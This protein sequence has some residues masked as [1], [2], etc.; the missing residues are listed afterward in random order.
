[1]WAYVSGI[2]RVPC[3]VAGGAPTYHGPMALRTDG[4]LRSR[5]LEVLEKI[6]SWRGDGKAVKAHVESL[7]QRG[8]IDEMGYKMALDR[9][10]WSS[11]VAVMGSKAQTFVGRLSMSE[12]V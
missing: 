3:C 7:L 8:L 5:P 10:L 2:D 11:I 1:V 12:P 9:G 6:G 4:A